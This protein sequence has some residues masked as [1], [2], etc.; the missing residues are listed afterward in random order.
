MMKKKDGVDVVTFE[1]KRQIAMGVYASIAL[2]FTGN[3]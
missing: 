3:S 1:R 2:N